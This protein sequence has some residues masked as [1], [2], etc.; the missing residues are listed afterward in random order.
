MAFT[1]MAKVKGYSP[2]TNDWFW[3]KITKDGKIIAEGRVESCIEC[4]SIKKNND[5]IIIHDLD[6]EVK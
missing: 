2:E 5:F 1:I 4:H 6:G 3:A